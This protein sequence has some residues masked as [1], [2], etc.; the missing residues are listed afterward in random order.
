MFFPSLLKKIRTK[1]IT[2]FKQNKPFLLLIG[3]LIIMSLFLYRSYLFG[4]KL[5]LFEDYGSDSVRVSLPT[6]IFLYDW[7]RNGMPLWSD[8][9]GIGT[10]VLSHGDIIFDPF[11]YFLFIF[12]KNN[13]IYM[14]SYMAILKIILAGVFFWIFIKKFNTKIS[15]YAAIMGSLV[16][17][18]SGYMI[19]A[20]QHFVFSTI[21]VYLPLVMLGFEIWLQDK[22]KSFLILMLTLTS[23]YFFYFFYMT[24][25]Y[26]VIYAIF[27]FLYFYKLTFRHFTK[28]AF[29]LFITVLVSVGLSSFYWLPFLTLTLNNLRVSPELPPLQYLLRI[30]SGVVLTVFARILG[31]DTLGTINNY[32]GYSGDYFQLP[33]YVG[34]ITVLL[35]PHIFI[36]NNK[37]QKKA[38]IFLFISSAVILFIP[39]FSYIFNGAS[40]ITYRWIY[41][42]FFS[43]A[44]L[45]SNS[46]DFIFNKK[47]VNLKL[48]Y[49]TGIILI[50]TSFAVINYFNPLNHRDYFLVSLRT[51][52]KDY[53]LI[54][55]Y[56]FLIVSFFRLRIKAIKGLILLL[57]CI[58][59]V[60][61]PFRVVN[62]RLTTYPDPVK[63]KLGYF[64]ETNDAIRWLKT[65]DNG[66]YRV[67]KSYDSVKSEFGLIS[68]NNESMVQGYRGLKSYNANNQPNYIRF[69]QH[70]DIYVK[71]PNPNIKLPEEIKPLEIKDPNLNYINGVGDRYLLQSFLGIK[72]Y[73]TNNVYPGNPPAYYD[74]FHT[75]NDVKIYKNNNYLPLGF[76]FDNYITINEFKNLPTYQKDLA[77]LSFVIIENPK[78]LNGFINKGEVKKLKTL[79]EGDLEE[80]IEKRREEVLKLTDYKEDELMATI[81]VKEN[82]ILTL[83]IPF[84][85]GWNV[86]VNGKHSKPLNIDNGL[87]GIKLTPGEN[88]I[89]MRYFP[90]NLLIGIII[91]IISVFFLLLFKKIN[92]YLIS[93]KNVILFLQSYLS[94]A[95]VPVSNLV[96]L[97]MLEL[98][99]NKKKTF[100]YIAQIIGVIVFILSGLIT[101]GYTFYNFFQSNRKDYFMD[102]FNP[103]S[104]L[105]DGPYSHGSIYP[106]LPQLI[107]KFMLRLV[108][109]DI[110]SQGGFV[111]RSSQIGQVVFLFYS[112]IALFLFLALLIEVKK[113]LKIERYIFSFLILF[114]APFLFLFER[115]NMIFI[116]LLFLMF[117]VFFKNSKKRIIREIAIISLAL[118]TAIKLYP[119]IFAFLLLKEKRTRELLRVIGYFLLL[120]F[121]P[122][123]AVGGIS[124][125]PVFLKNVFFTSGSVSDWG[126][127]Y[128]MNIQN[129]IRITFAFFGDFGN[130]PILVGILGSVVILALGLVAAFYLTSKW[131]TVSLL[132]LLIVLTP[133]ISFEYSLIFMTIPLIMF[134][135][136]KT[137]VKGIDFL[138]LL[139]FILI[140]IPFSLGI[141]QS[142]TD[143]F[144]SSARP[145]TYNVLIQNFAVFIMSV[146]LIIEGF[147]ERYKKSTRKK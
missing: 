85:K 132:S 31:Y 69:L 111:I 140:F 48:L 65:I 102:F 144:G 105:F 21:Y 141:A 100:F 88:I 26:F 127:G 45:L 27:R 107:Y 97:A 35:I 59:L 34:L 113:G 18:F 72:Y 80:L 94:K 51:F 75:V 138:Y 104:E 41:V 76:T 70:S 130:N 10:S 3:L 53:I 124:Q 131:K 118:S 30:D 96:K 71:N 61:F 68:S 39:F 25:F 63:N 98:K 90:P 7:I 37:R 24:M 4:G 87:I 66:V 114:S 22:K 49:A 109:Y 82:R 38:Y 93:K 129:I 121:L 60:W 67:D 120:F 126:L 79:T 28:Y 91:S 112:L 57:V 78:D 119:A 62:D 117:F 20:G 83:T 40:T 137:D 1:T 142:L 42:L 135:D 13:I 147:T 125:L 5:F 95:V 101:R 116:A 56:I 134:L 17:A 110:A 103:L 86:H 11:T 46:V 133:N 8:K 73:L 123:F 15:S 52:L 29:S 122:F 44:L 74:Y 16:Y 84:D 50:L 58:E 99:L 92:L 6:Y 139:S 19:V 14:F 146:A 55:L 43:F 2:K 23:L 115:G 136:E 9:M 77:L 36:A 32:F 128:T 143:G 81:K 54:L 64:D 106:P 33:I 108:P 12:G 89:T 47:R 145:L